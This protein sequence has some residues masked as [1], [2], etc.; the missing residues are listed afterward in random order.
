[1]ADA[2]DPAGDD[3]DPATLTPLDLARGM[4]T[5][6]DVTGEHPDPDAE[7]VALLEPLW[8]DG[9]EPW[10]AGARRGHPGGRR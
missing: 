10:E 8:L 1:M 3:V 5:V 9:P 4:T 7:R 6:A 2:L